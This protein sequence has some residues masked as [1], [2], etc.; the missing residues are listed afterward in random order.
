MRE[1]C[2][3]LNAVS[4]RIIRDASR[5]LLNSSAAAAFFR[6]RVVLLSFHGGGRG[7]EEEEREA[8]SELSISSA[9]LPTTRMPLYIYTAPSG[10]RKLTLHQTYVINPWLYFFTFLLYTF[11]G[12]IVGLDVLQC[13]LYRVRYAT[14]ILESS[15]PR[16]DVDWSK[17]WANDSDRIC[18]RKWS[19]DKAHFV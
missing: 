16:E 10:L 6:L 18:F 7:G 14:K 17:I 8:L 4:P 9:P 3:F 15:E 2:C 12:S 13:D 11:W 5:R 19:L 1:R